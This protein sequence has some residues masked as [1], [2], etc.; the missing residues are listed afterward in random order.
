MIERRTA[1]TATIREGGRGQFDVLAD[2]RVV[3]SKQRA[4]RFPEPAEVLAELR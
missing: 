2:G 1:H 3:F 4:R